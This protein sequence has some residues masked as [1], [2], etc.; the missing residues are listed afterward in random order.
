MP[1]SIPGIQ[2]NKGAPR[3]STRRKSSRLPGWT[4]RA[5]YRA[6]TTK[7]P[8]REE[9]DATQ[10]FQDAINRN[11]QD[12]EREQNQ[13]NQGI[14]HQHQQRERPA[15]NLENAPQK[16]VHHRLLRV[17]QY[18]TILRRFSFRWVVKPAALR[19]YGD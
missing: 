13:P 9:K 4:R 2:S 18:C 17:S 12:T 8:R 3:A 7:K 10:Q 1:A 6:R 11:A 15:Q 19:R 5:L 16:D 14:E